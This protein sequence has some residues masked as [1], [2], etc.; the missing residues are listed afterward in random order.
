MDAAAVPQL[1]FGAPCTADTECVGGLCLESDYSPFAFCSRRC[2]TPGDVCAED[3]GPALSFCAALPDDLVTPGLTETPRPAVCLPLC[4]DLPAC[5]ALSVQWERCDPP[6][7]KGQALYGT[8]G[9]LRVCGAPSANGKPITNGDTCEDW[10]AAWRGQ[11]GPQVGVCEAMCE[12]LG[13]CD[14]LAEGGSLDCCG[15]GCIGRMVD[16]TG[17]VDVPYEKTQ[18]CFVTS[19]FGHRGTTS[20]CKAPA[21]DCGA[22]PQDPSSP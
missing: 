21:E 5:K 17:G 1:G 20:V 14:L 22:T 10:Q 19:Y 11:Y 15:R 9:G 4:G 6:T 12:F 16:A 7:W 3:S 8:A 13:A 2:D 18:K